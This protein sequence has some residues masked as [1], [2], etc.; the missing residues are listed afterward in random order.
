[1]RGQVD[2]NGG[3][4]AD[5]VQVLGL[6]RLRGDNQDERRIASLNIVPE[7]SGKFWS[8]VAMPRVAQLFVAA[9]RPDGGARRRRQGWPSL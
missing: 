7:F 6:R 8:G 9:W 5:V 4:P 1:M 3:A 2:Q